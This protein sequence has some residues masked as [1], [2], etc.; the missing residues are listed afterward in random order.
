MIK[1]VRV[2]EWKVGKCKEWRWVIEVM[3][4]GKTKWEPLVVKYGKPSYWK[5][6]E[7]RIKKSREK[8]EIKFYTKK[9]EIRQGSKNNFK[10]IE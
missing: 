10:G 3:L 7:D 8:R 6:I 1:N 2:R 9:G 4:E 5:N